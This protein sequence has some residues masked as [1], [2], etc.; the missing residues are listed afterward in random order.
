MDIELKKIRDEIDAKI[1]SFN[2]RLTKCEASNEK[3]LKLN[4][5][6]KKAEENIAKKSP[7]NP[8]MVKKIE[9]KFEQIDDQAEK[10]L[11]EKKK[12][13]LIYFNIPESS[14]KN[15]EERLRHD[16]KMFMDIYK[17][18]DQSFA[19][20]DVETA[21]RVGKKEEKKNRPMI[22]RFCDEDTKTHFLKESRDLSIKYEKKKYGYMSAT[23]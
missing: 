9:E 7:T 11:I 20:S 10:D 2:K 19:D 13:N 17:M 1:E 15:I 4:E 8:E 21:Y 3:S 16:R 23:T 12:Q 14:S 22:V 6:V 18:D 5:R